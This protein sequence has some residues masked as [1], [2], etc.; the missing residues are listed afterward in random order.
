M[1]LTRTQKTVVKIALAI[2]CISLFCYFPMPYIFLFALFFEIPPT[3]GKGCVQTV[4]VLDRDNNRVQQFDLQGNYINQFGGLGSAAGQMR[5]PEGI[6]VDSAC[7]VWVADTK[8]DRIQKFDEH[9]KFLMAFSTKG[10]MQG[11][12]AHPMGL[13]ISG[14]AVFVNDGKNTAGFDYCGKLTGQNEY[15]QE[16]SPPAYDSD[17]GAEEASWSNRFWH[18]DSDKN[19]FGKPAFDNKGGMLLQ[20]GKFGSGT[21]EFNHPSGIAICNGWSRPEIKPC[22]NLK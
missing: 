3:C 16:G 7:D 21:G 12:F 8:N 1:K 4:F 20:K 15:W 17:W 10:I 22:N 2:F 14:G 19:T 5:T 13:Y 11:K 6:E 9:G 18:F